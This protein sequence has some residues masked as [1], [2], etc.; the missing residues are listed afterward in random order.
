MANDSIAA[1]VRNALNAVEI[2]GGG[3]LAGYPI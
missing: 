3:A 2:P 1:A